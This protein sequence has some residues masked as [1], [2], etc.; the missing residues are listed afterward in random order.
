MKKAINQWC[1]PSDWT[2]ERVFALCRQAGFQ[3]IELCVDYIPFFEAMHNAPR[4]GLIAEVP[5]Y[6]FCP[7]EGIWDISRKI[8]ILR[9]AA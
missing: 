1:F 9:A 6:P 5:P 2:W 8:D 4:E 3:G 7:E